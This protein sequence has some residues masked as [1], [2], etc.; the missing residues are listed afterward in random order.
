MTIQT[1]VDI[2]REERALAIMVMIRT[3]WRRKGWRE[4]KEFEVWLFSR[5]SLSEVKKILEQS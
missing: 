5:D 3:A 1:R 4:D 2:T